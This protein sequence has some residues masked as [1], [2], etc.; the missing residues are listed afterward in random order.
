M[1]FA[2]AVQNVGRSL[3]TGHYVTIDCSESRGFIRIDDGAVRRID[4]HDAA[5]ESID[6]EP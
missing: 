1:D 4:S 2:A 6:R 5:W 3:P